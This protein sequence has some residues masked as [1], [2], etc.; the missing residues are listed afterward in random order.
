VASFELWEVVELDE[1]ATRYVRSRD[2][3]LAYQ[4]RGSGPGLA[5]LTGTNPGVA[6]AEDALTAAYW[7]RVAGFCRV[8][9]HDPRGT[10]RSDPLPPGQP[11]SV[12]DQADD[13]VAVLDD[14]GLERVFIS[15]F[16]A[17]GGVGVTFAVRYPERT[18]GLFII[19]GWAR[20]IQGDGY[21]Y[22][23]TRS[24]SDR[25]IQAHGEQI[26]TGM[27]AEAFSPSRVGDPAVKAFYARIEPP[28]RAQAMLLTQM[29]QELDVRDLLARV[30][31]PTVV[32]HSREN[33]AISV[34]H[35]RYLA[36]GIPGA[37]FV[38]LEGTDH[39][40]M[41]ENPEP[42]LIEL[43]AF[44]TGE[45]PRSRPDHGFATVVFT[46]LVSSTARAAQVGDRRWRELIDRY[47]RDITERTS[48][49]GGRIAKTTGDG[50]LAVFPVPSHAVR[51]ANALIDVSARIDL[52]SRVGMHAGEVE[53]RGN[54]VSGL[55]VHIG[56]RVCAL[57]EPGEVLATRTVKDVLVGSSLDFVDRGIHTL[58]GV[59]DSWQ[60]FS[61]R[62]T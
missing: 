56:A 60:L 48:A 19:N 14:A 42:V 47:E 43:E 2:G 50:M 34:E 33:T 23:M 3:Q 29:A 45:R 7:E 58:K 37:R 28:S 5:S 59:P 15:T 9:V 30:T 41:L 44:V 62:H 10:G 55:A 53:L 38:D 36:S 4:V 49:H 32:M 24:F 61:V 12:E 21:P 8:V 25:L 51:C 40:V 18:E 6:L 20:M 26:G 39:V 22:G 54:D 52:Q 31:V 35:G 11:P 27:F 1:I 57:A 16:H 13:L 46:D 17:G